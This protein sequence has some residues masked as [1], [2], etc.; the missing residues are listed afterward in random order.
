MGA[1]WRG[2]NGCVG[3]GYRVFEEVY[4]IEEEGE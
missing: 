4:E 3:C 2:G 1:W